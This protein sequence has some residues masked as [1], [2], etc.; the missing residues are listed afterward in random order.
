[1]QPG[2]RWNHCPKIR[3][4]RFETCVFMG[5]VASLYGS[6]S[7][8]ERASKNIESGSTP[9][10]N[11]IQ[12]P[13]MLS[14]PCPKCGKPSRVSLAEPDRLRCNACGHDGEVPTAVA[15]RFRAAAQILGQLDTRLRRLTHGQVRAVRWAGTVAVVYVVMLLALAV[16]YAGCGAVSVAGMSRNVEGIGELL[17][18]AALFFGPAI[19]F[20]SLAIVG[21][22]WMRRSLRALERSA[23]AVPPLRPGEPALCHVCGGPLSYAGA[24]V[25]A[26]CGFCSA[27]NIV[28]PRALA[29]ASHDV[30]L[31]AGGYA[32][33]VTARATGM[34]RAGVAA[35][36]VLPLIAVAAP[37]VVTALWVAAMST[38]TEMEGAVDTSIPFVVV[39]TDHGK[40]FTRHYPKRDEA[41]RIV[42]P[43]GVSRKGLGAAD[44]GEKRDLAWLVGKRVRTPDTPFGPGREGK[45]VRVYGSPAIPDAVYARFVADGST[46]EDAVELSSGVFVL[47]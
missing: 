11:R 27:D 1:M 25:V 47:E 15:E 41:T 17:W 38:A 43:K 18:A 32:A 34:S 35:V 16:P 10:P 21:L 2:P 45:I 28:T 12:S 4:G 20:F 46:R 26:Q 8:P 44:D 42:L 39:E 3:L 33:A 30:A 29:R 6:A 31:D 37:V 13:A 5:V 24:A 40:L 14:S 36:V 9:R 19:L 22:V 7:R 23:T